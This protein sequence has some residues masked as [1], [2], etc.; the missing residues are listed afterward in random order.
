MSLRELKVLLDQVPDTREL[1]LRREAARG[2]DWNALYDAWS[3]AHEETEGAWRTWR[4]VGGRDAY[5]AY[6]AA[7]DREDAAQ[8]A[9]ALAPTT[10]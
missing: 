9:V 8:D 6:R 1:I 2:P 7:A 10:S 4:S 3:D 5:A